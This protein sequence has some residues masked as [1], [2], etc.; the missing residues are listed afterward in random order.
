[1]TSLRPADHKLL[2]DVSVTTSASYPGI[3]LEQFIS[4]RW[5]LKSGMTH[6]IHR[7]MKELRGVKVRFELQDPTRKRTIWSISLGTVSEQKFKRGRDADVIKVYDYMKECMLF[8][9]SVL[10][11]NIYNKYLLLRL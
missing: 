11:K 7:E 6:Q 9:G 2:L 8:R 10:S 3:N 4:R 5:D 1:M